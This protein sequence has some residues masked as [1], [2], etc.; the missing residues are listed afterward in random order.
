MWTWYLM[1][2]IR[3]HLRLGLAIFV[4]HWMIAS[5]AFAGIGPENLLVVVNADSVESRTVANHYVQL[6]QIPSTNVVLL[7]NIPTEMVCSLDDFRERILKPLLAEIDNRGLGRQIRAVAYSCHF[8]YGVNIQSHHKR[9]T[10]ADMSKVFT[11]T[12]SINGL[13][14]LFRFIMADREEYLA[15]ASN[16]YAR[17]AWQ[18]HFVN[19][20]AGEDKEKF[21]EAI[22][23]MDAEQFEEADQL[24]QKLIEKYPSQAPLYILNA[25]TLVGAGRLDD[26]MQSLESAAKAGWSSGSSLEEDDALM[27]LSERQDFKQL[28]TKL[29]DIPNIT[30]HAVAFEMARSWTP[31]GWWTRN[32]LGGMAYLPSCMLAVTRGAGTSVDEAIEYLTIATKADNSFPEGTFYFTSTSDVRTKTRLA[33]AVEAVAYLHALGQQADLVTTKLPEG[34]AD[35]LGVT[36]GT[37][38]YDW[39]R[40]NSTLLPGAIGDNLTSTSGVMQGS[41]QT[42]LTELLKAGAAIAS[43]T[44]TEPYALQ[45]KFPLPLIHA[46]YAEGYSAIEAYYLSVASPY[47]LL[48]VGDPL[49]QP[50]AKQPAETIRGQAIKI[51][52]ADGIALTT[53]MPDSS[54]SETNSR[55]QSSPI[56]SVEFFVN[57]KLVNQTE[58][59]DFYNIELATLPAGSHEFRTV[60]IG[61]S[62]T[63]PR[64]SIVTWINIDKLYPR[65]EISVAEDLSADG[66]RKVRLNASAIGADAIKVLHFGEPVGEI[67]GEEGSIELDLAKL[68]NGPIRL[69]GVATFRGTNVPC[70]ELVIKE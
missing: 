41:S 44:V 51:K 65:P 21:D 8:P 17:M 22:A 64:K 19:P 47:Q 70:R 33:G 42:V 69:Q 12:A 20:F 46:F 35:V 11:P 3:R 4:V 24:F 52:G 23:A 36:F 16:L 15:P 28:V 61:E 58:P 40:T 31:N 68:G 53:A 60:L 25:R 1:V 32:D 18:R 56:S 14:Y 63:A 7:R 50:F 59:K 57:G 55:I 29:G 37:A 62:R 9:L 54:A 13:T 67:E 49:C 27:P 45:F 6:R 26:A 10:N 43:G 66:T 5:T 48:I 38:G 2:T 34:K 39:A 30:Q